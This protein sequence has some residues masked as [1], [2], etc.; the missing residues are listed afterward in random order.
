MFDC[1]Y[2]LNYVDV[3]QL[4]VFASDSQVQEAFVRYMQTAFNNSSQS[5]NDHF[6]IDYYLICLFLSYNP[7]FCFAEELN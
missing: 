1:T 6:S 7:Q 2:I 5:G 4:K 3:P